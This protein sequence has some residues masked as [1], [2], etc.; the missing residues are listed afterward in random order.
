MELY[1]GN[2]SYSITDDSL[3]AAFA[4]FGEIVHARVV[5]NRYNGRSK[6]FGFVVMKNRPEAERAIAAMNEADLEGRKLRVNEAQNG[7][8]GFRREDAAKDETAPSAQTSSADAPAPEE[9]PAEA[10]SAE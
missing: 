7:T 10:P 4:R 8:V 2:L 6:G 1:V 3:N 9:A 5:I